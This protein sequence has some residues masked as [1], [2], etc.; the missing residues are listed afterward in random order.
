L[1][2]YFNKI[3]TKVFNLFAE[4]NPLPLLCLS[5]KLYQNYCPELNWYR[6]SQI[7][8]ITCQYYYEIKN[9][10]KHFLKK[11][12]CLIKCADCGILFFTS[13]SNKK[14][15]IRCPFGCR[16][17]QIKYCNNIRAKRNYR[18]KKGNAKKKELNKQRYIN[19]RNGEK[20]DKSATDSLKDKGIKE[21]FLLIIRIAL[22]KWL[23]HIIINNLFFNFF[24]NRDNA[25]FHFRI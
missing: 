3:F 9:V 18:G 13:N 16:Q 11:N 6:K 4:F 5:L 17:A 2:N 7:F 8:D 14:R 25:A 19:G 15:K 21:Y 24:K 1:S 23:P 22:K 10:K 20:V 12:C